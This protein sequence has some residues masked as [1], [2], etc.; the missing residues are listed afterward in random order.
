MLI[1][2]VFFVREVGV[3]GGCSSEVKVLVVA[4]VPDVGSGV[5]GGSD[6]D[7][8]VVSVG[9]MIA[10]VPVPVPVPEP[11]S[12]EVVSVAVIPGDSPL[13]GEVVV[14]GETEEEGGG[15]VSEGVCEG[16]VTTSVLVS[17]ASA[18]VVSPVVGAVVLGGTAYSRY[19]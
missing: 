1:I 12:A 6:D 14:S 3:G 17:D 4:L 9:G 15:S 2:I 8:M 5:E 7:G 19:W 11:P 10:E 16:V 18:V 13:E